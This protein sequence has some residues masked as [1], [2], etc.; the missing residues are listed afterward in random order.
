MTIRNPDQDS[1]EL[2]TFIAGVRVHD[3]TSAALQIRQREPERLPHLVIRTQ[4]VRIR[5]VV[6]VRR[7][8]E[9]ASGKSRATFEIVEAAEVAAADQREPDLFAC[10]PLRG[11]AFAAVAG[12]EPAA[13][14]G[15]V[16]RPRVSLSLRA[17]D[18]QQLGSP[19]AATQDQRDGGPLAPGHLVHEPWLVGG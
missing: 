4:R 1:G 19:L 11:V 6:D 14:K 17:L 9:A 16:T 7:H 5:S 8:H 12:L 3:M 15:H 13:R 10:L 18:E 2:P